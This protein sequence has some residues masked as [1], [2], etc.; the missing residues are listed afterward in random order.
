MSSPAGNSPSILEQVTFFSLGTRMVYFSRAP[1]VDSVGA[2]RIWPN[3]NE[4]NA[5]V[6][7]LPRRNR[8]MNGCCICLS[9]FCTLG[10]PPHYLNPADSSKP[11][12]LLV[13][14]CI[15]LPQNRV[16]QSSSSADGRSPASLPNPYLSLSTAARIW[17]EVVYAKV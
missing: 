4:L 14:P 17:A 2:M 12:N 1:A 11:A 15:L 10:N 8:F 13:A 6:I 5:T 3:A 16:R 7:A 9:S